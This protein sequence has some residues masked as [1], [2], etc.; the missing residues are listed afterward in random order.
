M[1][2]D[3]ERLQLLRALDALL[4]AAVQTQSALVE[5]EHRIRRTRELASEGA[6][7]R[8]FLKSFTDP[9]GTSTDLTARMASLEAA[10]RRTRRQIALMGRAE[11][12]SLAQLAEFWGVSRQLVSR[13]AN[14][15]L[16]DEGQKPT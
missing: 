13:Y 16:D 8:V 9:G 14:D 3:P 11:G 7:I 12:L 4:D 15:A 2:I 6:S 5:V 1:S 10:R